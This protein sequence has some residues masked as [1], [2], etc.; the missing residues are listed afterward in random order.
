M[1]SF[2]A[3][4]AHRNDAAKASF[5]LLRTML[6]QSAVGGLTP[7]NYVP[8]VETL[9]AFSS[10]AGARDAP[11]STHLQ[12]SVSS[13]N[14][15]CLLMILTF[16]DADSEPLV[17]RGR[18]ALDMIRDSQTFIHE[19]TAKDSLTFSTGM[20]PELSFVCASC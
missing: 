9:N 15:S 19:I 16:V 10:A 14:L 3:S 11:G 5:E 7:Q 13:F 12:T 4:T 8:F 6:Y 2:F 1:F 18:V 20:S 17:E